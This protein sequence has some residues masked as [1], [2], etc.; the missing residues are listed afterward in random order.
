MLPDDVLLE[1]F[2][3]Y[4]DEDVDEGVNEDEEGVD[5][6]KDEDSGP[7]AKYRIEGWITL[8]H[9]CRRWRTIVFQSSYRLNLRL[10]CTSLTPARATL[11]IWPRPLPLIIHDFYA[12]LDHCVDNIV[13]AL[14]HNDRVCQIDL[15]YLTSPQFEYVKDSAEMQKPFQQ[16]TDL[17]LSIDGG[18]ESILPD[19]FL[20]GT[21]PRLQSLNLH[22]VPFPG[23]PKLLLSAT[24]IVSLLLND[25]PH[26][27]YIPPEVMATSLSALTNLES[28]RLEFRCPPPRAALES[29]RPPP[30]TRSILSSLTMIIFKGVSEY[31]E[32]ILARIDAPRVNELHIT[33]FNQII[34]D[35]PQ[36]FQFI[37]RRP[38][39]MAPETGHIIFNS[40]AII[41]KFPP[42]TSEYDILC[43][44]VPCTASEWQLSSL[45]QVCASSLPPVSMLED[46]YIFEDRENPPRWQDDVE[47]TL[48]LDLLRSF[49][50][51]K[52][53]YL[54]DE[55]VRHI[56][57]AL[58]E[59]VGGRTTEVLP[60]LE[61]IFLDSFW[62]SALPEG[63]EKFVAARRL[64]SH[65]VAVSRWAS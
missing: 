54:S 4:M 30:P 48:W 31:L 13:A 34:F 46:L 1:I 65:P 59:L 12:I 62:S 32:E 16:L 21:A 22:G 60:T 58:Q 41:V 6:D 27:G 18:L 17:H 9:V 8:A 45:E 3:F 47:N 64:T 61:N 38:A 2:D 63:I 52:N 11:D 40:K 10:L 44:R 5:E 15:I 53:L 20:G 23:L 56:A 28:L 33:F 43:V 55:S 19:S 24:H 7:S 50:A 39:L 29:R 42:Q 25:I 35:T 57:P 26:S 36:L 51:V 49:V 14:E 37:G